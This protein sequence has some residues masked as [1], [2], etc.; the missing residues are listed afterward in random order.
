MKIKKAMILAAGKGTRMHPLT[1]KNPKPLIKIGKYSL[2]ERGINL[3]IYHGIEELVVNVH[4]LADQIEDFIIKKNYKIKIT[5]SNE[6]DKLLDTGGGIL[7]GT[8]IFN[9]EPFIVLNPDTLW[10]NDYSIELKLLEQM[11]FETKK[12]CL[13][14]VNKDLSFDPTFKGDFN[15]NSG[16]QVLHSKD[17]QYIFT[18]LQIMDRSIFNFIKE[19]LFS[20]N[21][22]WDHLILSNNLYGLKSEKKFYHLNTKNIYDKITKLNFID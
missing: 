21:L 2:L 17:C 13:L 12:T 14:L 5:V 1:L 10:N 18:G 19:N 22:V 4:Y 16:N 8:K 15:L 7:K 3:L 20:M 6:I 9:D 11:Y